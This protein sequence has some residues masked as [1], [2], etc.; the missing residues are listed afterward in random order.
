MRQKCENMTNIELKLLYML[1][2]T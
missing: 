2:M 1:N